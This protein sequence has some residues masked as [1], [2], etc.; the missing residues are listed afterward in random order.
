MLRRVGLNFGAQ[1]MSL[2]V[3][4]ADR[5]LIVGILLRAW[6]PDRYADWSVL[7]ATASTL[8]LAEFGLNIYFG[9]AW[10]AAHLRGNK[11]E[12]QRLLSVAVLCYLVLS[13]LLLLLVGA[14]ST[15]LA[16]AS[17]LALRS[18][19]PATGH[20]EL[21]VLC[22]AVIAR[23]AR[24]CLTQ[25]YRGRGEFSRGTLLDCLPPAL[26][27]L[28]VAASARAGVG[29][30]GV[31]AIYLFAELAGGWVVMFVDIS[32]RY[33][34]LQLVPA[35]PTR[36]ELARIG[37][38][39]P[40]LAV[41]QGVPNAWTQLPVTALGVLQTNSNQIVAFVLL[42]TLINFV[43]QIVTMLALSAGV[44][45]AKL[46]HLAENAS[47]ARHVKALSRLCAVLTSIG[48]IGVY[49]FCGP[50]MQLWTGRT[51][52]ANLSIL[53]WLIAAAV[54]VSPS[55][56]LFSLSML[57]AD[58]RASGLASLVQ[59]FTGL[60]LA[61]LGA[62]Q[63]GAAGLAAGLAAGEIMGQTV[64]LP[65]AMPKFVRVDWLLHL[66]RCAVFIALSVLW[67]M[68]VGLSVLEA[69]G[70]ASVWQFLLSA[71]LWCLLGAG[72]A[73]LLGIVP[74]QRRVAGRLARRIG[75]L[76]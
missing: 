44:E 68:A 7:L 41:V 28:L 76:A 15:W 45:L 5:L 40:W 54:L 3:S 24:G 35:W 32:Q 4:L 43:R 67:C 59:L 31:A 1:T 6:G 21:L 72:P 48:A 49:L 60:P 14:A 16:P 50:L 51:D 9:N 71:M 25:L 74:A 12:F 56:P 65:L 30:L 64:V 8:G 42:R 70:T 63:L 66:S 36:Y 33:R 47:A 18:F 46:V 29:M 61:I 69:V 38:E 73:L 17:T 57:G 75:R 39:L 52:I 37:R 23:V 27:V 13:G 34:H 53:F 62:H 26:A 58:P 2:L 19:D 22:G 11:T 20:T 55:V 10:Q